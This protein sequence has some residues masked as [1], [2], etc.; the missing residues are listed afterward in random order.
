MVTVISVSGDDLTTLSNK[1]SVLSPLSFS[2]WGDVYG[3]FQQ[4]FMK[5]I[6]DK[7]F[8]YNPTTGEPYDFTVGEVIRRHDCTWGRTGL[9]RVR[10]FISHFLF[11]LAKEY[12]GEVAR[13]NT[14]MLHEVGFS[15]AVS[16]CRIPRGFMHYRDVSLRVVRD[17]PLTYEQ[18]WNLISDIPYPQFSIRAAREVIGIR[19]MAP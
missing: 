3:A 1:L 14:T 18:L 13:W 2:W 4:G 7:V 5:G 19:E 6:E 17:Y 16:A 12:R 8:I 9:D 10:E 15:C 11:A